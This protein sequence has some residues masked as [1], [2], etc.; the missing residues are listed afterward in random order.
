ME[1]AAHLCEDV[2]LFSLNFKVLADYLGVRSQSIYNHLQNINELKLELTYYYLRELENTLYK[3]L[4]GKSGDEAIIE[5]AYVYRNHALKHP[6]LYQTMTILPQLIDVKT[7]HKGT[8]MTSIL[9]QILKSYQLTEDQLL[10][11]NRSL[12]SQVHGF[13][14]LELAGYFQSNREKNESFDAMIQDYLKAL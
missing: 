5:F 10:D 1:A 4:I 7:L 8:G 6:E 2:G 3:A 9:N 12:R 11:K 13:V 14:S